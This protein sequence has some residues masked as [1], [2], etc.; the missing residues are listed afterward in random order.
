MVSC[1]KTNGD[2]A[3]AQEPGVDA[4][5]HGVGVGNTSDIRSKV[6]PFSVKAVDWGKV[7][8][9]VRSLMLPVVVPTMPK[10]G[11]DGAF[12]V[13]VAFVPQPVVTL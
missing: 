13:T 2:P 5:G 12:N 9:D 7:G 1:V 4:G 8:E 6:N 11:S 10:I 3:I